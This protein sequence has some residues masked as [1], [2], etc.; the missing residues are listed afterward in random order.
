MKDICSQSR[1]PIRRPMCLPGQA[2][3]RIWRNEMKS[4][5]ILG[6]GWRRSA[7]ARR[8][9][10]MALL[11]ITLLE[12]A[13][14]LAS[15]TSERHSRTAPEWL[16]QAT[17]YQVWLRSF[18]A[19]GTLKAVTGRL[20]YLANLGVTFVYLS[21]FMKGPHP[22][23]MSDYY[24]INPEH[25]TEEDLRELV[26][27]AHRLKLKVMM[28]VVFFHS[29]PDNVLM[30]DPD[31]YMR[32][33]EG[34]IL[35]GYFALP[36]LNFENPKL[37]SYLIGNLIH[38]V[39][40]FGIDG[41]R[42]DVSGGVPLTFWEEARDALDE[43][44]PDLVLLAECDMPEE[45]IKAFD[46]SYDYPFYY[47]PLVAVLTKGEPANSLREHWERSRAAFPHGARFLHFSDNH[48]Q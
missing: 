6:N 32:T 38:W 17:V 5:W 21:P 24:A 48:D 12:G 28:D 2:N 31:N 3:S 19:E 26:T 39:K 27:E 25:G 14:A 34:K 10:W 40:D 7:I 16:K 46:V 30:K 22:F 23:E 29:A 37:R 43:V 11:L 41:F 18:S 1:K 15:P 20:P 47:F 42:C 8:P 13:I 44:K 33:A 36:R 4:P 9:S 35:L 45:Q